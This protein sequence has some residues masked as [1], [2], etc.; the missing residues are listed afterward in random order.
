MYRSK[1][2]F[3]YFYCSKRGR[4]E[5]H[6]KKDERP[7]PVLNKHIDKD[8]KTTVFVSNLHP[9]VDE[10]KLR[11]IFPEATLVNLVVDRK[12]KSRCYGYVQFAKE[13][14]TLVALAKD[15]TPIDGRPV[16]V[17][18]LKI[19]K[20][21]RKPVFKYGTTVEENKLFVRGLPKDKT[22]EEVEAIFKPFNCVD[23]RL[24]MHKNG[25]SKGRQ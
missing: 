21:E 9:S 14:Q 24:V 22:K 10:A 15:R 7:P 12:G 8:P 19:E 18:E 1:L 2:Q 17:S 6:K 16:F 11:E 20:T 23:V 25:Q 3:I 5:E 4:T 13:E